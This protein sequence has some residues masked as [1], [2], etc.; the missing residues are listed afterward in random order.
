MAFPAYAPRFSAFMAFPA[1]KSQ[2]PGKRYNT[3]E[4]LPGA[5]HSATGQLTKQGAYLKWPSSKLIILLFFEKRFYVL[6][7]SKTVLVSHIINFLH[8]FRIIF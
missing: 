7:H 8:F 5:Q 3:C 6:Y 2:A 1:A 4:R